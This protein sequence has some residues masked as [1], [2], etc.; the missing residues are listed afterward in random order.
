MNGGQERGGEAGRQAWDCAGSQKEGGGLN[1]DGGSGD[2]GRAWKGL[3]GS[4]PE[5][6]G[7]ERA[8]REHFGPV[9][10]GAIDCH[11]DE[12]NWEEKERNLGWN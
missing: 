6:Q 9:G 12:G 1:Q 4:W 8:G 7:L 10:R 5:E 3:E 11:C 2:M